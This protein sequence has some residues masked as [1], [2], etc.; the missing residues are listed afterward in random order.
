MS[1]EGWCCKNIVSLYLQPFIKQGYVSAGGIEKWALQY[2]QEQLNI[3]IVTSGL[4]YPFLRLLIGT[5]MFILK[6]H[7]P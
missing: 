6:L 3:I 5:D 2:T 7:V 4:L 1:A